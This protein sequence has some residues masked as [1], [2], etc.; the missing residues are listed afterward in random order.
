[1]WLDS[2]IE[3][4]LTWLESPFTWM[5][6]PNQTLAPWAFCTP[7]T[8]VESQEALGAF[9]N[10]WQPWVFSQTPGPCSP[11]PSLPLT[12]PHPLSLPG[13]LGPSWGLRKPWEPLEAFGSLGSSVRLRGL[14]PPPPHTS[15]CLLSLSGSLEPSWGLR[16]PWEP[17]ASLRSL[18]SLRSFLSLREQEGVRGSDREWGSEPPGETFTTWYLFTFGGS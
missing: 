7:G 4:G 8:F 10:L 18:G 14:A 2:G 15:P 3:A 11:T 17:W 13:P 12:S 9:G 16:K 6:N 1:M 5:G